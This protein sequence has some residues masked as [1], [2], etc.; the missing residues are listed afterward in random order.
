MPFPTLACM[1]RS[2]SRAD[3]EHAV[4]EE[5]T[6]L[7]P[8]GEIAGAR[9]GEAEVGSELGEDVA[10]RR[11]RGHPDRYRERQP[12]RLPAAVVGILSQDDHAHAVER[13][14]PEGVEDE[15]RRRVEAAAGSVLGRE[16]RAQTTHCRGLELVAEGLEPAVVHLRFHTETSFAVAGPRSYGEAS[17]RQQRACSVGTLRLQT[18][19]SRRQRRFPHP[20]EEG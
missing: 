4:E 20:F 3:G 16:K 9:H 12:H 14:Q 19:R 18:E 2:C 6:A 8:R 13:R 15:R 10:E 11:G 7:G 1:R 5:H 17:A